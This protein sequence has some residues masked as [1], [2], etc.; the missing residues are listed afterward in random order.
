MSE[1][2][3]YLNNLLMCK[4]G[5]TTYFNSTLGKQVTKEANIYFH[6]SI[7]CLQKYD[8]V[9]EESDVHITQD[10]RAKLTKENEDIL[11]KKGFLE[12][13]CM[14]WKMSHNCFQFPVEVDSLLQIT[15]TANCNNSQ[16]AVCKFA[17]GTN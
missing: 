3:K 8:T 2:K 10:I 16:F 15:I 1:Q 9:A 6:M 5:L 7:A 12:E 17:I 14:L 13:V 4:R 11:I